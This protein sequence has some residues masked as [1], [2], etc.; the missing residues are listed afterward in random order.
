[1]L[2]F[3]QLINFYLCSEA[4][5]IAQTARGQS[6]L[7][8]LDVGVL[9]FYGKDSIIK[10]IEEWIQNTTTGHHKIASIS[11]CHSEPE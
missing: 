3:C 10:A 1:M 8:E 7:L 9:T 2:C 4:F 11:S 5:S 6:C